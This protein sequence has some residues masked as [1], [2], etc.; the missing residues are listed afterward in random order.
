MTG[1][2]KQKLHVANRVGLFATESNQ[3]ISA[4]SIPS[5]AI[6][7]CA[8]VRSCE[9]GPVAG[10]SPVRCL[11]DDS[12]LEQLKARLGTV[13]QLWRSVLQCTHRAHSPCARCYHVENMRSLVCKIALKIRV[14]AVRFCPRPPIPNTALPTHC[15]VFLFSPQTQCVW[16]LGAV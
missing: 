14:S 6:E 9:N 13:R 10:A 15:G 7:L 11:Q 1:T 12:R 2:Y 16:I 4:S 5:Y 3:H 8:G